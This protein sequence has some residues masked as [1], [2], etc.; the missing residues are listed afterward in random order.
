MTEYKELKKEK[1]EDIPKVLTESKLFKEKNLKIFLNLIKIVKM[2]H[3]MMIFII[4]YN[5]NN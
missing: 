1:V 4:I 3:D 5:I 2:K